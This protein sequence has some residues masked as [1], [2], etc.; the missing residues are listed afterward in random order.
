MNSFDGVPAISG[1]GL[2]RIAMT[3]AMILMIASLAHAQTTATMT[4]PT[5]GSTVSG[6]I[7]ISAS[8]NG[9]YATVVFWHDNWV[10]IGQSSSP[11]LSYNT[12]QLANGSHQFFVS[13]LDS[14]GNTLCA[15][16]IV[17]VS[18]QN[19][20]STTATMTSPAD[21]STVSGTITISASISGPYA[22]VVYWHDNWVQIAQSSSPSLS[23]DTTT[24]S[25][26]SHQ[27]FVSVL[28]SAGNT[29]CASN[30]VTVTVQNGNGPLPTPPPGATEYANLQNQTGN[31][32]T[33]TVCDGSC[34]GSGGTG[35]SSLTFGVA[36][37]SRSGAS[38]QET[39]NGAYWD[40]LYYRHLGCP[41]SG[42]GGVQNMLVDM[43]FYPQSTNNLQQLEF[44]PDLFFNQA[45]YK[46]SIACR[47]IGASAG[48]WFLWDTLNNSWVATSYPCDASTVSAGTWHHL[49][50]YVTFNTSTQKYAYQTFVYDGATVFQNLGQ[51]FSPRSE[52]GWSDDVNIEQ[53]IDNNSNAGASTT[54]NYDS[55]FRW[56]W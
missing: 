2:S 7:T 53:Q 35:S 50:L 39:A 56:V 32:G 10:Q 48:H 16:N 33:W 25:N 47:L 36:S 42:C 31:P 38:M 12:G 34:S 37:P 44:D 52:P 49:Q 26:G 27:F 45:A 18:I 13:V 29:L 14:A 15:S 6:N 22:T 9:P 19:S 5:D 3:A 46:G 55:Y 30:I 21:G 11:S 23:F 28:D 20:G 41:T 1:K 40:T 8:I 43:W 17:T 54:V 51:S 24:L 4:S